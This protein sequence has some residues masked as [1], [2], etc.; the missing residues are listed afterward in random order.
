[1]KV[2]LD[3][4][5]L[6]AN[7]DA[8]RFILG[9][10]VLQG[11]EAFAAC[12]ASLATE[13]FALDKHRRI[14]NTMRELDADGQRIG[15]V[16]IASRL[17]AAGQLQ[18]IDGL[19]YLV[20]LDDGLPI[21]SN[22]DSYVSIVREKSV[23]RQIMYA[24]Q[25]LINQCASGEECSDVIANADTILA[26][27]SD[28]G[29]SNPEWKN[30]GEVIAAYPGGLGAFI[31]PSRGG[32]GIQLPWPEVNTTVC[33]LQPGDLTL[34]A[35]RP[36]HGKSVAGMQIAFEAAKFGRGVAYFSL[37][38][39]EESLVRRLI[40]MVA[41]VDSQKMRLGYL[42]N[43]ER[44]RIREAHA[45]ISGMPLWIDYRGYTTPAIRRA[46]KRL[47]ARREVSLVVV[48]HFHLLQSIG[49]EEDRARYA[50]SADDLQRYAKE[51][52]VP[53]VVLTQLNRK[54]ED[55]NRAPGLSDL[56]ETGKLEQNADIVSFVYR[57]EM[58][59]KNR[60]KDELRGVAEFIIAKQRNG[61][62]GK[63]D[64]VFLKEFQQFQEVAR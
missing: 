1:M 59:A 49:R 34:I 50:R 18:S 39:S 24:C 5:G 52:G 26:R 43:E 56:A 17:D 13:D 45:Y 29:D 48:D 35:G 14:Y 38:M 4:R 10:I 28:R 22:L 20:S 37:E 30:P 25:N 32:T 21:I 63:I 19:S 15:R 36:S 7:I 27:L 44:E 46:V 23:L 58:Y 9:S 55:E 31:T 41:H 16:E 8:E 51:F 33:G 53:F 40:S 61:P 54:C 57:P 6:P 12:E 3:E 2:L 64:M 42:S 60:Q 47:K 62:V 11:N